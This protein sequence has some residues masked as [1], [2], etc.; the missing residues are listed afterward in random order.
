MPRPYVLPR[1]IRAPS[2]AP[3]SFSSDRPQLY[4]WL[5]TRLL[6]T[7]EYELDWPRIT[8]ITAQQMLH[9][10]LDEITQLLQF[11]EV[12]DHQ[13]DLHIIDIANNQYHSLND[14]FLYQIAKAV[15][16]RVSTTGNRRI[17]ILLPLLPPEGSVFWH[18]MPSVQAL[19]IDRISTFVLANDGRSWPSGYLEP[20][21]Q[22][23]YRS[24]AASQAPDLLEMLKA[25]TVVQIGHYDLGAAERP[26]CATHFFDTEAAENEMGELTIRWAKAN[27]II[28]PRFTLIGYG[29]RGAAIRFHRAVSGA[30]TELG[31]GFRSITAS[32][33]M[34]SS[35]DVRGIAV[36]VFNVVDRGLAFRR[37]VTSL[38]EQGVQLAPKALTVLKT[39]PEARFGRRYP[40][41]DFLCDSFTRKVVHR[42]EC[43]QCRLGLTHTPRSSDRYLPVRTIDMW[44]ILLECRWNNET[45][46]PPGRPFLRYAPD[47]AQVFERHG[48]WFAYKIGELLRSLRMERDIVFVCPEEPHVEGLLRR[49]GIIMQNRQVAVLVPRAVLNIPDL[50]DYLQQH[51]SDDWY[52]QLSYLRER[53][54]NIVLID[55]FSRTF[56]TAKDLIRLLAH[57]AFGLTHKAYI[58]VIDFAPENA[59]RPPFTYPLYRLP[60]LGTSDAQA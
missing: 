53:N 30:A 15:R 11:Q 52:I 46:G 27:G 48:D 34:P 20:S 26:S 12:P 14:I 36:L 42:R 4:S 38:R 28:G 10:R 9:P 50:D 2:P 55:E 39:Y 25:R 58:P 44:Q 18:S 57:R 6:G 17:A 1:Y 59:R 49:L 22:A 47:M 43:P 37:V 33:H 29:R 40:E 23:V 8:C 32:D 24:K 56:T 5:A 60:Y 41:L 19:S 7:H 35:R 13:V 51:K 3:E 21:D 16:G 45:F 31:C 54:A